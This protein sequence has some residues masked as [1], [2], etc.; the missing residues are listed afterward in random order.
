MI[1]SYNKDL[2]ESIKEIKDAF[3]DSNN[4]VES[5][6]ETRKFEGKEKNT[7]GRRT[8]KKYRKKRKTRNKKRKVNMSKVINKKVIKTKRI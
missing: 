4:L 2:Q 6:L 8:R 7:G 1:D 3:G 5:L